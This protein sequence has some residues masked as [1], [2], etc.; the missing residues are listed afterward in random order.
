MKF[1]ESGKK[2]L[3]SASLGCTSLALEKLIETHPEGLKS[4]L[5]QWELF[6]LSQE[7][8]GFEDLMDKALEHISANDMLYQAMRLEKMDVVKSLA[9][10]GVEIGRAIHP[11]RMTPEGD[12]GGSEEDEGGPTP[13][14]GE[15]FMISRLGAE[16]VVPDL[17]HLSRIDPSRPGC[18]LAPAKGRTTSW[19]AMALAYGQGDHAEG[20]RQD[21]LDSGGKWSTEEL[22]EAAL[23]WWT[24]AEGWIREPED[25][26]KWWDRLMGPEVALTPV[27]VK[28]GWGRLFEVNSDVRFHNLKGHAESS[29]MRAEEGKEADM[30]G[31]LTRTLDLTSKTPEVLRPVDMAMRELLWLLAYTEIDERADALLKKVKAFDWESIPAN[32]QGR[33]AAMIALEQGFQNGTSQESTPID[34]AIWIPLVKGLPDAEKEMWWSLA[35]SMAVR[36]YAIPM[37]EAVSHFT[38]RFDLA[39]HQSVAMEAAEESKRELKKSPTKGFLVIERFWREVAPSLAHASMPEAARYWEDRRLE[40]L[41]KLGAFN[42]EGGLA[43]QILDQWVMDLKMPAPELTAKKQMRM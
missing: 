22:A 37:Q 19:L 26:G 27:P 38:G 12:M 7:D 28:Q 9:L 18:I 2:K 25:M 41:P 31:L 1:S 24:G 20:I 39:G 6:L 23:F 4:L 10:R 32:E 42:P 3:M 11:L 13:P 36:G 5:A 14:G 43:E 8:P 16:G 40:M 33:E 34:G 30:L 35:C 29:L 15:V 21:R 17:L